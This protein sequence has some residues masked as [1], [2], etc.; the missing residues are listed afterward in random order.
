MN[1]SQSQFDAL[2]DVAFNTGLTSLHKFINE[3]NDGKILSATFEFRRMNLT[4]D[5]GIE[6]RRAN[7]QRLFMEGNYN[8]DHSIHTYHWK[9]DKKRYNPQ[10]STVFKTLI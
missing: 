9:F 6:T 1:L 10:R 4:K 7:E 8:Y 3:L 5:D 2:V